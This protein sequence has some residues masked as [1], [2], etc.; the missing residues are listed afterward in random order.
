MLEGLEKKKNP[1]FNI[2]DKYCI[3][4]SKEKDVYCEPCEAALCMYCYKEKHFSHV[5]VHKDLKRKIELAGL[6]ITNCKTLITNLKTL[7]TGVKSHLD[8]KVK[9]II[10]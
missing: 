4:H 6:D 2:I 10:E 5:P 9:E 8:E 1:S 7:K 3:T